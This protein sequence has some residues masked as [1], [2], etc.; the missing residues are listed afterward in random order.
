MSRSVRAAVLASAAAVLLAA[1]RPCPAQEVL[2]YGEERPVIDYDAFVAGVPEMVEVSRTSQGLV[3]EL[4]ECMDR[5]SAA[6]ADAEKQKEE[7]AKA[8]DVLLRYRE[9]KARLV[10]LVDRVFRTP[11]PA[12]ADL[13]ILQRLRETELVGVQW[14][15][16]RYI[17]C[18]RDLARELKLRFLLH[19]DVLKFNTV[20]AAFPKTSADGILRQLTTGFDCEHIVYNGEIV[21]IKAIKRN[22]ARL[23]K[24][25]EE[26]PGWKYWRP[27]DAP[28]IEDDL[29]VGPGPAPAPAASLPGLIRAAVR[30][31]AEGGGGASRLE[32]M[33]LGMLQRNMLKIYVSEKES[34]INRKRLD[35]LRIAVEVKGEPGREGVSGTTPE[36]QAEMEERHKHI[37]HYLLLEKTSAV[38]VIY[39]ADRVLGTEVHLSGE[40][41]AERAI[42]EKRIEM[43]EIPKNA[44]GKG[45]EIHEA[46]KILSQ[47]LGVPVRVKSIEEKIYR[48]SLSME[49]TTGE[50]VLKHICSSLP[51]DYFIEDGGIV[52]RHRNLRGKDPALKEIE[53]EERKARELEGI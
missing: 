29:A 9:E 48:I 32:D 23:Q 15:E 35:E 6:E 41:R 42:L 40:G 51:F 27:K 21:V 8:R 22:D 2:A 39:V 5:L 28:E 38:Q 43:I 3:Q 33:D 1:P 47:A 30:A 52:L 44:A 17:D 20:D 34:A 19:P 4:H 31:A 11:T 7:R 49:R 36:E 53:E 12:E 18:L 16:T 50:V 13:A 14:K 10:R 26:H 46:A 25:L 37:F 45:T 24:W